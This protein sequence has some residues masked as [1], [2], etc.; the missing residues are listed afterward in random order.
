[1]RIYCYLVQ[2]HSDEQIFYRV[3][4]A[5]DDWPWLETWECA[6][7]HFGWRGLQ[8]KHIEKAQSLFLRGFFGTWT[9]PFPVLAPGQASGKEK[10]QLARNLVAGTYPE[11]IAAL[12]AEGE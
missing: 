2:S 7:P 6:C 4:R 8:C 10:T 5:P 11:L 1:M 9:S 3:N 12:K